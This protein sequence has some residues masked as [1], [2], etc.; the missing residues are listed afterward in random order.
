MDSSHP[1]TSNGWMR[2]TRFPQGR[3]S[4]CWREIHSIPDFIRCDSRCLL[5]TRFRPTGTRRWNTSQSS[6]A[7]S[8]LASEETVIQLQG[9]G[10]WEI[11]YVN[12]SDD[13]RKKGE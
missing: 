9:E 4:L 6:P 11:N 13:P 8:I 1:G 7:H 5:V 12:P 10:P 2:P 3:S